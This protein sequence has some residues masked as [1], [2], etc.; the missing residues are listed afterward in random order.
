MGQGNHQEA[1]L[2]VLGTQGHQDAKLLKRSTDI[3]PNSKL[4]RLPV[5]QDSTNRALAGARECKRGGHSD[6]EGLPGPWLPTHAPYMHQSDDCKS[7]DS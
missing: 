2:K 6:K 4:W 7:Q 5:P 1:L 3:A